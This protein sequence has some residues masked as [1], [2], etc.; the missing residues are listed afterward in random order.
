MKALIVSN[1]S[2]NDYSYYTKYFENADLILCVDG[3][4]SHMMSFDIKPD[5][6]LGD[7]D[8]I[9]NTDYE[10][11]SDNGVEILRFPKEKDMS[12]T[13]LA[14]QIA[15][16][17]GCTAFVLI[18]SLGTRADHSMSN[19]FLL[20]Q[21]L[22][23]GASGIIVDEH[24]EITLIK[25]KINIAREENL[26]VSLLPITGSIEGVTTKGLY[27]PLCDATLEMGSTWGIS[28]EFTLDEAE[29]SIKNGLMLVIKSR[30]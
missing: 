4:A 27:Y 3:A 30:D 6:L 14:I 1:G 22:D 9:T 5:I 19:I 28:N 17:R 8:S 18:G 7:F 13:E 11:F 16:D 20:K 12:D 21:L 15:L 29:V 25:D 2:I 24:N 23:S 10:Y 26:R